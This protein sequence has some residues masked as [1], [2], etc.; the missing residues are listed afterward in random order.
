LLDCL[1]VPP[2]SM[3]SWPKTRKKQTKINKPRKCEPKTTEGANVG[4]HF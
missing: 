2:I 1:M 3:V 4:V